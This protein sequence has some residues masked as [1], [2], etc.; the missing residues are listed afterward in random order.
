L[1][2]LDGAEGISPISLKETEL[3]LK[4]FTNRMGQPNFSTFN[5]GKKVWVAG[6]LEKKHLSIISGQNHLKQQRD[7]SLHWETVVA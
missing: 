4:Q 1:S 6:F 5:K 2:D 3:S 7:E